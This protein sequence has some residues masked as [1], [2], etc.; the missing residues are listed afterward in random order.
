MRSQR[1]KR[2]VSVEKIRQGLKNVMEG[3][4]YATLLGE[5]FRIAA[6][7]VSIML[8]VKSGGL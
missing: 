8:R 5:S 6:A 3:K 7:H 1:Y 2:I 4:L